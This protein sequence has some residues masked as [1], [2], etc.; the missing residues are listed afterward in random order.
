MTKTE[1][2]LQNFSAFVHNHLGNDDPQPT[3]R[4]LF[5]QWLLEHPDESEYWENVASIRQAYSDIMR[6]EMGRPAHETSADL[7]REL[8]LSDE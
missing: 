7:R 1:S 2:D 8:G 5:E 6:G 3:L 4:E